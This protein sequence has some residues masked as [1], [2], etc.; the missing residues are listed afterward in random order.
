MYIKRSIKVYVIETNQI[1]IHKRCMFRYMKSTPLQFLV[2]LRLDMTVRNPYTSRSQYVPEDVIEWGFVDTVWNP[3]YEMLTHFK[4]LGLSG[5][6]FAE[7]YPTFNPDGCNISTAMQPYIINAARKEDMSMLKWLVDCG[8]DLLYCNSE[9]TPTSGYTVIDL[10]LNIQKSINYAHKCSERIV[11]S[12]TIVYRK[13]LAALRIFNAN[14]TSQEIANET[15][16]EIA[17]ETSQISG[18]K[19]L[20]AKTQEI[21]RKDS[22]AFVKSSLKIVNMLL[23]I[24]SHPTISDRIGAFLNSYPARYLCRASQLH[25]VTVVRQMLISGA[26]AHESCYSLVSKDPRTTI[27]RKMLN[28][29]SMKELGEWRPKHA[30]QYSGKYKAGIRTLL[31]LAQTKQ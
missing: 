26:R 13:W 6:V 11:H 7:K 18:C 8:A 14:E 23:W 9:L 12:R 21:A 31:C 5:K 10:L 19:F 30:H 16:Q 24:L 2:R 20:H 3:S 17:N 22:H 4:A 29:M 28:L 25:L 15:S 27:I 1:N